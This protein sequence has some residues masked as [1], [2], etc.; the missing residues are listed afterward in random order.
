MKIIQNVNKWCLKD[1][2]IFTYIQ[3]NINKIH[4]TALFFIYL[5]LFKV[6]K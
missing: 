5:L 4:Q 1:I 3:H 6:T 2:F